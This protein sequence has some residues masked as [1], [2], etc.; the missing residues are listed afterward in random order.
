MSVSVTVDADF[1]L[2]EVLGELRSFGDVTVE[3]GRGIV[4]V[5]GSGLG[6]HTPAMAQALVA[7]GELR[8]HMCSLSASGINLTMIVD[9]DQV[10]EAMR[11]LHRAFFEGAT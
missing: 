7:L 9:G 10:H 11:R 6:A 5:V 3:R 2:E 4:V 1:H 8:L